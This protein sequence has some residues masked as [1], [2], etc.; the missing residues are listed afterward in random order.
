MIARR[1]ISGAL[2]GAAVFAVSACGERSLDPIVTLAG[3]QNLAGEAGTGPSEGP[4]GLCGA[5]S[6][7]A[8]CGDAND[9]CVRHQNERFCGRDC[10]DQRGCPDGYECVALNDDRLRQCVPWNGCPS[11]RAVPSREEV[12][13]YIL[14][15]VNAQRGARDQAPLEPSTCLNGLAEKSALE[16]AQTDEPLGKYVKECDPIWPDCEC[17]WSAEAEVAISGYDLDWRAAVDEAVESY[18]ANAD[19]HFVRALLAPSTTQLGIGFWL[20]GDELW[21]ALSLG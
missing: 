21:I 4:I 5:C 13:D 19:T 20:S 1:A 14:T 18:G 10:D 7:S 6:S 16:F 17:G 3:D 2:L 12:R 8:D 9:A 11:P 15:R